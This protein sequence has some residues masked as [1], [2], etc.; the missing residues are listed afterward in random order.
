MKTAYAEDGFGKLYQHIAWGKAEDYEDI[1]K[2]DLPILQKRAD[3]YLQSIGTGL[4]E[5]DPP[6][7]FSELLHPAIIE[8][9]LEFYLTDHLR[10]AVLNSVIAVFDLIRSR[11]GVDQDGENLVNNVFSLN[12]PKLVLSEIQTQSGR[13][14]QQGFSEILKGVYKGIR[15]PKAHSLSHDLTEEKT[16]QYL[17]LSSLLARRVEEAFRVEA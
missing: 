8:S 2:F 4:A 12:T 6:I 10:E 15:N 3:D 14:D 5:G 13:N 1:L 9:S 11:S 7:G 16:A 17:I